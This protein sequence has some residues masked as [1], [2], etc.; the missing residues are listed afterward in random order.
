MCLYLFVIEQTGKWL[1][2]EKHLMHEHLLL[3][4]CLDEYEIV[5]GVED[6]GLLHLVVSVHKLYRNYC[7]LRH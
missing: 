1:C 2:P 4:G 3:L 5:I 7:T 6:V